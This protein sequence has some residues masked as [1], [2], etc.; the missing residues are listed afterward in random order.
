MILEVSR[1]LT[2]DRAPVSVSIVQSGALDN[3]QFKADVL[4]RSPLSIAS[5][6]QPTS[7]ARS[8]S[9]LPLQRLSSR[10]IPS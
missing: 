7:P 10:D 1:E 8:S 9:S 6:N 3:A 4:E 2:V 5:V